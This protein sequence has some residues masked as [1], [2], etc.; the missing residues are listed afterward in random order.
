MNAHT[1]VC[2]AA[3][4]LAA[5]EPVV[6]SA[7]AEPKLAGQAPVPAR[8]PCAALSADEGRRNKCQEHLLGSLAYDLHRKGNHWKTGHSRVAAL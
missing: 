2:R 1:P 7:A 6:C 4:P 5:K 3:L 8:A